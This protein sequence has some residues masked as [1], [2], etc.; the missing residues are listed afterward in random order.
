ME[1]SGE[2]GRKGRMRGRIRDGWEGRGMMGGKMVLKGKRRGVIWEVD[3]NYCM[4]GRRKE[5]VVVRLM[6]Y[7]RGEIWVG[8][9]GVMKVKVEWENEMVEEVVVVGGGREKKVSV[10]GCMR[11]VKG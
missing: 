1:G 4:E 3:G 6:G 5:M 7:K 9:V 10:S 8:E 11:S 2:S